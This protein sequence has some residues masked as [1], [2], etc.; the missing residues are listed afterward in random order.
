MAQQIVHG[1]ACY[2]TWPLDPR[3]FTTHGNVELCAVKA[4]GEYQNEFRF[5]F[6]HEYRPAGRPIKTTPLTPLLAAEGADFGVVNGWERVDYIKPSADFPETYGFRFNEVHAVVAQEVAAVQFSVGLCEV[7]GFNRFEI[8][9]AD[10]AAFL[11]RMTCSRLPKSDGRVGLCYLLNHQGMLK[12]E[13]TVARLPA[14]HT[15]AARFWYGSA[16]ASEWHV[17]DWLQ[18]HLHAG[19]DVQIPVADQ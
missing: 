15:G 12:S 14:G 5:E 3:R 7:N 4:I 13:A 16:A 1:E 6:P 19:E 11:D 8:T 9:G 10:A 2:V 17:M 18:Q